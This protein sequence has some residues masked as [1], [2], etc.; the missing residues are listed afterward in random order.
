MVADMTPAERKR[1]ER[2]RKRRGEILVRLS[3]PR[4]TRELLIEAGRLGEWSEDDP[5]AVASAIQ[6]LLEEMEHARVTRDGW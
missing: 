3:I 2:D 5:Q 6:E 1:A 4:P